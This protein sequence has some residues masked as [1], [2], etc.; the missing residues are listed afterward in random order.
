MYN[1]FQITT[2]F[3]P[4]DFNLITWSLYLPLIR[5]TIPSCGYVGDVFTERPL[6]LGTCPLDSTIWKSP[7][8]QCMPFTISVQTPRSS[9][10]CTIK[11]LYIYIIL[12]LNFDKWLWFLQKLTN[13]NLPP[14]S[15][16]QGTFQFSSN[17]CL[18]NFFRIGDHKMYQ[19]VK[20]CKIKANS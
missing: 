12:I 6:K 16:K 9:C 2:E 10:D 7:Y 14:V 15:H 17:S 19:F 18:E 11:A 8:T 4:L 13:G 20:F 3:P 5:L 1:H